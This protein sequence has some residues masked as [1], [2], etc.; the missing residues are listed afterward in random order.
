M[1]ITDQFFDIFHYLIF[2]ANYDHEDFY[3]QS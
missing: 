2:H 3:K 1:N